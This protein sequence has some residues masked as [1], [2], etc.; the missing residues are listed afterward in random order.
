MPFDPDIAGW[1]SATETLDELFQWF[2]IE[3][4]DKLEKYGYSI[5]L[6]EASE[7]KYYKNHWVINQKKSNLI[8]TLSLASL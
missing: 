6:Y 3:D 5:C 2:S 4:I 7:Y 8:E 1:L